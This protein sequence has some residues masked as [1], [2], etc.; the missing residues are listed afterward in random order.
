M[1]VFTVWRNLRWLLLASFMATPCIATAQDNAE[2]RA[3]EAFEGGVAALQSE[4]FADA[5]TDF[6]E[7]YRLR[8]VPLVLYNLALT[9]R[10]LHRNA[11]ALEAFAQYLA[12]PESGAD[13]AL[14]AA[15]GREADRMRASIAR[16]VV[17]VEPGDA[18]VMI[19]GRTRDEVASGVWLDPGPHVI[20]TRATGFRD[21]RTEVSA[22]A[23]EHRTV[24][25]RNERFGAAALQAAVHFAESHAAQE[26]RARRTQYALVGSGAA[27]TIVGLGVAG[28]LQFVGNGLRDDYLARC[29]TGTNTPPVGG[30]NALQVTRR[31]QLDG[32][33]AGTYVGLGLA[34][35]GLGVA[36]GGSITLVRTGAG[37]VPAAD[38]RLSFAPASVVMAARW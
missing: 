9:Y 22:R 13:P 35:V 16:I 27:A 37:R 23:G 34:V 36:L 18:Q 8:A 38:V 7:S 20:E 5:L 24:T 31:G 30:C 11:D 29:V 10:G 25:V 32:L 15:V 21:T 33:E 14:L 1:R 4:R 3:R 26:D 17:H 2:T 28:L 6:R 19:D 12:H